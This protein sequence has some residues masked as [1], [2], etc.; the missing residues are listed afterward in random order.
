MT[1]EEVKCKIRT[2]IPTLEIL[3]EDLDEVYYDI[4]E[5]DKR[6]RSEWGDIPD[7]VEN[8]QSYL[9]EVIDNLLAVGEEEFDLSADDDDDF[10]ED[11]QECDEEE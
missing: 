2:L 11:V 5:N 8:A 9:S 3:K 4:F 7:Y 6:S 1:V 10:D